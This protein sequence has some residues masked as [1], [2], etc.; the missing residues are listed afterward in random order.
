[1]TSWFT[2]GWGAADRANQNVPAWPGDGTVV[3]H[4]VA[5][6]APVGRTASDEPSGSV[7]R[8]G[9]MEGGGGSPFPPTGWNS[10]RSPIAARTGRACEISCCTALSSRDA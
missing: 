4:P 10:K 6:T 3:R 1:M 7:D 5:W 8:P 2:G 9:Q